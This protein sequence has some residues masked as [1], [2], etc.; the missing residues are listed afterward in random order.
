M[1]SRDGFVSNDERRSGNDRREPPNFPR[2]FSAYSRRSKWGRRSCDAAGYVDN[3]DIRT[4]AIALSVLMLSILDGI[5]TA[6]QISAGRVVE[7]NPLM[8]HVL[9]SGGAPAFFAIKATLTAL[10]LAVIVLH[11]EW[12]MGKIAA[13]FCLWSYIL[14]AVYHIYLVLGWPSISST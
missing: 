11:K 6:L 13:R 2:L 8:R 9:A 7:A 12:K 3:Y 5:L 10:A 14:I 1:K 4:W